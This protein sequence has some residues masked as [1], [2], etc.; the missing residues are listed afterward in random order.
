MIAKLVA[1]RDAPV[2]SLLRGAALPLR[3]MHDCAGIDGPSLAWT[4]LARV[5]TLKRPV[6]EAF[7]ERDPVA[8]NW[9]L[10]FHRWPALFFGDMCDRNGGAAWT[11]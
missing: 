3:I 8:Q 1:Q 5:R 11:S 4:W 6:V 10:R 2:A 9:R 7:S